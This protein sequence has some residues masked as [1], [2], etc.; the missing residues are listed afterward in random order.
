MRV[1]QTVFTNGAWVDANHFTLGDRAQLVLIFA[2]TELLRDRTLYDRVRA[3]YPR[4]HLCGCST[5]G[6]I[7]G[8]RVL[9]DSMVVTAVEFQHTRLATAT[10][11]LTSSA[12]SLA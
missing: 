4:A 8:T 11:D 9:D 2:A 7:G 1:E 5:A 10:T 6:E 3:A 12:G